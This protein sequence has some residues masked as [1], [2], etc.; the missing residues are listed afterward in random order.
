MRIDVESLDGGRLLAAR[1]HIPL[2]AVNDVKS[3]EDL[4]RLGGEAVKRV[5]KERSTE[6][7]LLKSPDG[8]SETV[9]YLKR[10][11]RRPLLEIIKSAL[12]LKFKF[13]GAFEEWDSLLAFHKAGLPTME[14]IAVARCAEGDCGLTLGLTDFE[15]ASELYPKLAGDA[16]RRRDLVAKAARLA[17]SMHAA[18]MAHQ[19][20]YLV[21]IFVMPDASLRLIDLQRMIRSPFLSRRWV[22]KDLAQLLFSAGPLASPGDIALFARVYA[23]TRRMKAAELK[24]L[25]PLVVEKAETIA[26]HDAKRA[27][28]RMK[29]TAS[30]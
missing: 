29:K 23:R 16:A 15:R 11:T 7:V 2:L 18:G 12:S 10:Y 13:F 22:V 6:R 26:R 8:E 21:H 24:R 3:A 14:P 28:A 1:N 4:W 25:V 27:A 19:D 5:L 9:A 17:G 20:F 30:S